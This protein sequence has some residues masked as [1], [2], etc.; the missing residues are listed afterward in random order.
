MSNNKNIGVYFSYCLPY[1]EY[2]DLY[3]LTA[4]DRA[5]AQKIMDDFSAVKSGCDMCWNHV[6]IELSDNIT[7][8]HR[9]IDTKRR[10]SLK[11]EN[12]FYTHQYL[13]PCE[14]MYTPPCIPTVRHRPRTELNMIKR[15][16]ENIRTG[17]C[18]NEFIRRTIGARLFPQIYTNE[19]TR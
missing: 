18:Q 2:P 3:R 14:Q 5:T 8:Y 15:C 11:F 9:P 12:I 17:K 10:A 13:Q 1:D 7:V 19:N 16:A 4:T 6:D